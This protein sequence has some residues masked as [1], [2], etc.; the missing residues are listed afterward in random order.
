MLTDSSSPFDGTP[1]A[2][3]EY[4]PFDR[5]E[6][7]RTHPGVAFPHDQPR[8]GNYSDQFNEIERV[9]GSQGSHFQGYQYR[10]STSSY[11]DLDIESEDPS[12]QDNPPYRGD[13]RWY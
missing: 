4:K 11:P 13:R 10:G 12:D 1:N 6:F 5:Q 9:F 8:Y 2:T 3:A 7:A